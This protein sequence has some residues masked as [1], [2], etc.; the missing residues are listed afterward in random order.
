[1]NKRSTCYLRL[2]ALA[3]PVL[4]GCATSS[5]P[6]ANVF[7]TPEASRIR[8]V[9]VLPFR[10]ATELIGASVSD[11]FV[12]ELMKTDRYRLIERGQLTGVLGETEIA[13]SGLTSGQ[14]ARVG[15]MAGAEAVILGTVA[16]YEMMAHRGRTLPVVGLSIRMIDATS[17]RVLWSVDHAARGARGS[18][19]AQH[20]RSVVHELT[21]ALT[22]QLR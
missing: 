16:E 18:T 14:A 12:T 17:G 21:A 6:K 13:L 11:M 8:N 10:A 9:A 20:S 22:S 7:V 15:Q 4:S 1:M 19:L 3:L 5:G 2:L